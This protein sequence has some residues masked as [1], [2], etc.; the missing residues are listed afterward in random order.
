[1][2]IQQVRTQINGTWHVLIYNS[3]T[4][5]YEKTITAPNTTSYNINAEHYYPVIVEA[6]NTAGTIKT[7][8]DADATLGSSLKL[9]VKERVKPTILISSPGASAFVTNNRQPIIFQLR[10]EVGGSGINLSS[11]KLQID[12]QI[13]VSSNSSGMV[14]T[15]VTNGYD[16]S[17]TPPAA[18]TDG[19]HTV[20]I[21]VS[22]F[23]DNAAIQVSRS[24]TIDTV[25]PVLNVSNPSNNFI[26]NNKTV[27]VQ[28]TTND[29]TSS[30]VTVTIKLN[31]V[32][33]GA[34]TVSGGAFNKSL[35]LADGNN[36]IVITSTDSA[37]KSTTVTITGTLDMSA[38]IINSVSITPNPV[39]A[40]ATMVISV[41]VTG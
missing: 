29:V 27:V 31:N 9:S 26:T 11:L 33:Q 20:K 21:D 25:P 18:L 7:I 1:M 6:T 28:G 16:C 14:C 35:T 37:G 38:P 34:V 8:N 22:D 3:S 41:V 32:D 19:A 17:Y 13:A 40:G 2:A 36:T 10:D 39:D 12:S 5:K 15:P 24:Y 23:D 30:A 4:G